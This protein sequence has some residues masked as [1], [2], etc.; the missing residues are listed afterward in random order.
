MGGG[1][2][3]G[4]N[5]PRG[6]QPQVVGKFC[7][8]QVI[9]G[10]QMADTEGGHLHAGQGAEHGVISAAHDAQPHNAHTDFVHA[11]SLLQA[12]RQESFYAR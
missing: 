9:Y 6:E 10:V 7:T 5:L 2:D 3:H 1:N 4:V 11:H 12:L 8:G